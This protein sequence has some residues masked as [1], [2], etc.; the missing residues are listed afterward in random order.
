MKFTHS[1]RCSHRRAPRR[2]A[3]IIV[4]VV[5][6]VL[7]GML[8][9]SLLKMALLHERQL[10]YEQ[11]R[12]QAAWL[13]DSGLERAASR[14]AVNGGYAGETWTIA[15][16]ELGGPEGAVVVIHVQ[17]DET[18]DE[19]R[20]IVVEAAYPAQGPHQARLTRHTTITVSKES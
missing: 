9:A 14:L 10:G 4:V 16:A 18:Q 5:C 1:R 11:A 20:A 12:L 19:R 15:A 17:K 2:G 3:F 13:A 7:A 6:L 8:L